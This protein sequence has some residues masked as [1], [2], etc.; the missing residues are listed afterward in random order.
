MRIKNSRDWRVKRPDDGG[1][2]SV[3]GRS[4]E[5]GT[6]RRKRDGGMVRRC[7]VVRI[8]WWEYFALVGKSA[9]IELGGRKGRGGEMHL[10]LD[11]GMRWGR[12]G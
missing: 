1:A 2:G 11:D 8:T 4:G 5:K 7:L 10:N 6:G 3:S 12:M 9:R